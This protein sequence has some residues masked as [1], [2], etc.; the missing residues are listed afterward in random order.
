MK[1]PWLYFRSF[2]T[3][4]LFFCS[5]YFA[6]IPIFLFKINTETMSKQTS[7]LLALFSNFCLVL[8][9]LLIYRKDLKVEWHRFKDKKL[10]NLD[11]GFKYWVIGLLC[12]IASNLLLQ[13]LTSNGVAENEQVVQSMIEIAPWAML[14]NAGLF[15]PITEEITFRKT[16]KDCISHPLVFTLVSGIIFG[17]L[18]V[19]SASSFTEFLYIIPYS[20]LG[21]A[22][23]YMYVKT[24]T[25][26]TSMT[27][28]LIHNTFLTLMAI[29][30]NLL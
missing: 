15:A 6:K 22:F 20:S 19:I 12:M 28:H 4:L 14:I 3:I 2:F 17:G 23:A 8:V 18:H 1:K 24:N 11:I 26:F 21:I 13:F 9:L 27:M 7:V 30:P 5:N 10:E 29:L 25:V 16:F